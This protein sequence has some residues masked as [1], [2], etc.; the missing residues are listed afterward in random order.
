MRLIKEYKNSKIIH[1]PKD[2]VL[3]LNWLRK[4]QKEIFVVFTLNS[5]H[6]PTSREYV[7]IGT[8]DQ[9]IVHPREVFRNAIKRN[10]QSIIVAHNHPSGTLEFSEEDIKVTDQLMRSGELLGIEVL[11]HLLVTREG[12]ISMKT[13]GVNI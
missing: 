12:Y 13:G 6:R 1:S 7:S 4:Q 11:D 3:R 10:A 5:Q 9:T 2:L 8:L